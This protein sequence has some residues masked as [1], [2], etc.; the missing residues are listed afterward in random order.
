MVEGDTARGIEPTAPNLERVEDLAKYHSA[1]PDEEDPAKGGFYGSI[2]GREQSRRDRVFD[3][4][5]YA[6]GSIMLEK[7]LSAQMDCMS[8]RRV[9]QYEQG[10][11]KRGRRGLGL[12][13]RGF[14]L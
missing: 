8:V 13:S 4:I 10:F 7:D 9:D 14:F 11:C 5:L 1:F 3:M 6:E 2:P 12:L